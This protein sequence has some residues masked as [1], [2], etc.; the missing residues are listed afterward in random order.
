EL[1]LRFAAL[2]R[3]DALV[4]VVDGHGQ[5]LLRLL[6]AD[7][8]LVQHVLNLGGDGDL[9]D[10]LGDLALLVLRQDLVAEGD[11]LIAN[12]DRRSGNELPDRVLRL[13]AEGAAEV[14][15]VGHLV[16]VWEGRPAGA[17]GHFFFPS[18][19]CWK[20][21]ITWSISPYSLASSA[22]MKRSRSMSFSIWSNALPVCLEIG[23]A[24]W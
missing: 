17:S 20:L 14:L 13:A 1:D 19:I 2:M 22:D 23:R 16:L 4:V 10:R 5:R 15:I 9:G 21:A 8:V 7:H 6:L 24:S 12:V 3:V 18:S 11:A